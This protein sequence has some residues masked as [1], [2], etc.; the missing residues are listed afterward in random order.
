MDV[1]VQQV[2]CWEKKLW[3]DGA[4]CDAIP[5]QYFKPQSAT[6]TILNPTHIL[7]PVIWKIKDGTTYGRID[8]GDQ[9][10]HVCRLG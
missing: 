4:Y 7:W 10:H 3:D 9:E 8:V 6:S 2:A 1:I 5:R